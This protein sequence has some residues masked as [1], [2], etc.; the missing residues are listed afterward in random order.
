MLGFLQ[1][2]KWTIINA[3]AGSVS[4]LAAF[5]T[6]IV[7][8]WAI[9]KAQQ[10]KLSED[11]AKRPDF[12][13]V[14]QLGCRD[15]GLH[16]LITYFIN[17]GINPAEHIHVR[18][19]VLNQTFEQEEVIEEDIA[20]AIHENS[21]FEIIR[22]DFALQNEG[23]NHFLCVDLRFRDIRSRSVLSQRLHRKWPGL[24]VMTSAP[25]GEVS[26]QEMKM[27]DERIGPYNRDF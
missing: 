15:D 26:F 24:H 22:D 14:G 8:V 13:M 6:V 27:I 18:I 3:I 5:A 20:S 4:A 9:N 10:D 25:F 21:S 16:F 7:A 17:R 1:P 19:I 11:Q 23:Q 2:D 12:T